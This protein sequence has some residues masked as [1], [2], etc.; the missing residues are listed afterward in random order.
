MMTK[1]QYLYLLQMNLKNI[2]PQEADNIM[3][4]YREYFE[5]AGEENAGRVIEELGPPLQLAN[6]V[7]ADY[8]IHDM[9]NAAA[10]GRKV[11]HKVSK[12]WMIVLAVCG[13]PIWFPLV[14]VFAVLLFAMLIVI[15]SMLFALA[16]ITIA[17]ICAG[18]TSAGVG[19]GTLFTHIPTGIFAIGTGLMGIGFGILGLIAVLWLIVLAER[20]FLAVAK[21]CIGK[22]KN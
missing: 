19:V 7:C 12:T 2:P 5:E 4:Y 10:D 1:E 21:K 8:V 6:R 17:F 9:Q 11:E 3:Q 14:L 22:K 20:A 13:A 15:F 18:V 16:V